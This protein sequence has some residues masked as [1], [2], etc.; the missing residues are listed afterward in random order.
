MFLCPL[1]PLILRIPKGLCSA[2]SEVFLAV[3]VPSLINFTFLWNFLLQRFSPFTKEY[4]ISFFW[5]LFAVFPV[6]QLHK[7][8]NPLLSEQHLSGN[9]FL[10]L[11]LPTTFGLRDKETCHGFPQC[12]SAYSIFAHSTP[13]PPRTRPTWY[14]YKWK[15]RV[16]NKNC[17]K[18]KPISLFAKNGTCF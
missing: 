3:R 1:A 10:G 13:P 12:P 14:R 18:N 11:H 4:P 2:S 8:W 17:E 7:C 15:T 16:Q 5:G 9:F 6:H